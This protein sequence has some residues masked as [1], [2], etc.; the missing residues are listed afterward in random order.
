MEKNRSFLISAF[1]T[2]NLV[3]I[4]SDRRDLNRPLSRRSSRRQKSPISDVEKSAAHLTKSSV[5][6]LNDPKK[7]VGGA[8]K[9]TGSEISS[10]LGSHLE[11]ITERR[12]KKRASRRVGSPLAEWRVVIMIYYA[13]I[14][15]GELCEL[16]RRDLL[17]VSASTVRTQREIWRSIRGLI[18][19]RFIAENV[20]Y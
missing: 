11:E 9:R 17:R 8:P 20:K 14:L 15:V 2:Q 10:V 16:W 1:R 4:K 7:D 12:L 5:A 19:P 18:I 3:P 13:V 6:E